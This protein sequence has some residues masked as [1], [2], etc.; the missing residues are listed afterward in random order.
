MR[1]L[2]CYLL[3]AYLI[4]VFVRVILSWFPIQHGSA[5]AQ[6]FSLLYRITEPVLGPLRRAIPPMGGLDLS[7]LVL[8]IGIEVVQSLVLDCRVGL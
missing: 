4:A 7:P 6:A 2:L 1:D 8:L 3:S 5:M